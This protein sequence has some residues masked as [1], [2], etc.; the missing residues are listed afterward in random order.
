MGSTHIDSIFK[1]DNQKGP[2]NSTWNSAQCCVAAWMGVWGRTD[3]CLCMTESLFSSPEAITTL[4]I[5]YTPIQNKKLKIKSTPTEIFFE[6]FSLIISNRLFPKYL[7]PPLHK[8]IHL[9]T[10]LYGKSLT[11]S[12]FQGLN[13]F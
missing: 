8:H 13:H 9:T 5:G 2:T 1:I 4:L 12:L 10:S 3:A 6:T 11:Y 7:S